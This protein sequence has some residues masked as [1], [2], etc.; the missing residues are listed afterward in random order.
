LDPINPVPPITTIF[1]T[2][3]P[4]IRVDINDASRLLR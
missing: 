2:F 1:M 3:P 4:R